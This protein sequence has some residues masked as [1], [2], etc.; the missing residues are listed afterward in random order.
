MGL[1]PHTSA[2]VTARIIGFA[3]AKAQYGHPLF[4]AAKRRNCFHPNTTLN[5]KL[6]GNW[7]QTTIEELVETYLQPESDG[8]DDTYTDGSIVQHLENHPVIDELK[9]PS[10]TEDGFRTLEDV[11][12]L[13][14]N[15][16][17]DKI[18]TIETDSGEELKVTPDH[19][20][21]VLSEGSLTKKKALSV[22]EG[23]EL[24]VNP[25]THMNVE[26]DW[27]SV[28]MLEVML[29]SD[30][31]DN[32]RV[33]VREM[34][35]DQIER[36]YRDSQGIPHDQYSYLQ[37]VADEIGINKKTLSNY[38]YRDSVPAEILIKLTGGDIEE[39]TKLVPSTVKIAVKRDSMEIP[40]EVLID[41]EMSALLGYY[42]AE[43][44]TRLQESDTRGKTATG[45][46]QVDIA[47]IDPQ[48][49]DF[50]RRVFKKKFNVEEPYENEKRITA[51]GT[52]LY[53]F[54]KEVVDGGDAAHNKSIP[55]IIKESDKGVK[56]AY[57][58]GYISGDGS[59]DRY[60]SMYTVSERLKDDLI[61]LIEDMGYSASVYQKEPVDLHE[62][63]P[64]FYNVGE[65]MSRV[66]YTIRVPTEDSR[67]FVSEHSIH[68]SRKLNKPRSW[69]STKVNNI[70]YNSLEN[71][72][73][74]NITVSNTH[75]IPA[76]TSIYPLNCDGD[77]DSVMLLMDGFLNFSK[78]FL[79]DRIGRAMDAPM[80]MTAIIDPYEVDDEAHNV[81]IVGEYPREWYEG[82]WELNCPSPK[83]LELPILE[84]ILD[85]PTGVQHSHETLSLDAG[86][87]DSMYVR[88]E[89]WG[90]IE[91][92]DVCTKLRGVDE[93]MVARKVL[94]KHFVP[95]LMGV[96]TSLTTQEFRCQ[97]C[98]TKYS[99]PP[100][101]GECDECADGGNL[102][103][104]M[105]PGSVEQ[106]DETINEVI[107]MDF[108]LPDY[109][110]QRIELLRQRV[111]KLIEDD[112]NKQAGLG[113][114]M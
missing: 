45:V 104:T 93:D 17:S 37:E 42:T 71:H 98:N 38:L 8:Y 54:F 1:A 34:S 58:S 20:L 110:E 109:L 90:Y 91:Q 75:R 32:N 53:V 107:E 44:F 27:I 97:A 73:T 63:F 47:N 29:H 23:E 19:D 13:T 92:L 108:N 52:P 50:I 57:L 30:V 68:L 10:I 15:T 112:T 22:E 80:I 61:E 70:S 69:S 9:V 4:H 76:E 86:P 41:E 24:I 5:V 7:Q 101:S 64:D 102:L 43:G 82:T 11:E 35:K 114:F 31:V 87:R 65:K 83:E 51:S 100:L 28:D 3:D 60:I 111:E 81:D 99:V 74:Y 16:S 49:K 56:G 85:D 88:A 113:E 62:R 21:E 48:A 103:L 84:D 18:V 40:R 79:P 94:E 14:K 89:G 26:Q 12:S 66:Q 33:M 36:V 77:E 105:Y 6:N 46:K 59:H 55:D 2:S 96:L 39:I 95:S 72:E 78:Q 67:R 106:W 25:D